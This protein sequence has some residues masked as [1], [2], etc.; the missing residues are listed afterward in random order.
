M[1]YLSLI[2]ACLHGYDYDNTY[3]QQTTVT[4]QDWVC[5]KEIYVT[6]TFVFNR[7]GE[8]VGTF[9]IGQMGDL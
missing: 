3:Y 4:Q 7:I 2:S 9:F 5:D 1:A 8:V 6:N